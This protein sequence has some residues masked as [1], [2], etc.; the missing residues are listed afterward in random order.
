MVEV[1]QI[2]GNS[3]SHPLLSPNDAFSGYEIWDDWSVIGGKSDKTRIKTKE[4]RE[5]L[6]F[7]YARSGLKLGLKQQA[8]IGANP[9]KFGMIGSTDAHTGIAVV[10]ENNVWGKHT[11]VEPFVGRITHPRYRWRMNAAGYATVW[12][13]DNIMKKNLENTK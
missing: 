3:E 5:R 13:S 12:A 9:F 10:A 4:E 8:D 1:T 6:K 11:V 2:K 7:E